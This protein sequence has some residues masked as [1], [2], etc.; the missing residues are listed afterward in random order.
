MERLLLKSERKAREV[1]DKRRRY[2]YDQIDWQQRLVLILG[3][4]GAG[5]T[6]LL[7]QRLGSADTKGIYLSLDDYFFET[8]RLMDVVSE[9][10]GKG[11][12]TFYLDE[13]HKY[14]HWSGDLKQMHDEFQE[15]QIVATGSS[16][17]DLS[18]GNADLSRRASVYTLHGLSFRE[19]LCIEKDTTFQ[20]VGFKD[21]LDHHFDL[22]A[23][24]LDRFDY[25][26]DFEQYLRHGYY[27]FYREGK[28]HYHQ[29]LQETVNLVLDS[30]IAPFEELQYSTV[31]TMKKLLYLIS[32]SVPFQPNINKLAG[33][34]EAPRNTIL[35]LL[36]ILD[37]AGIMKL[38]RKE[39]GSVSYLQ[40]PEKIYLHN[41][42]LIHMF[43]GDKA[44]LGNLRETFF[45]NQVGSKHAVTAPK[46]GDFLV[47]ETYVFE[48][49]GAS[50]TLTQVRGVPQAY[51]ALD[52]KASNGNS[53]P[54][55]MFGFLY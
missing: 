1:K 23:D 5:K 24:L 3:Y 31:R 13:V 41:T 9:L 48:I 30:D 29:K 21:I 37:Q 19:Y 52:V 55:W 4:R 12:R 8:N 17:L 39:S 7:L 54:L 11:F 34:L 28:S 47:D 46:Y 32:Q 10:Y 25:R 2:L 26:R 53:I 16:I 22:S 45:F 50:K 14:L 49:G 15:I 38:L 20:P 42:N 33:M 36:D 51:L 18:K 40:K 6:T 44:N 35:R 43:S 27:P